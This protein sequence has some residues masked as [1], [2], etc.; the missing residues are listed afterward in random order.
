M[1]KQIIRFP[2]DNTN[3]GLFLDGILRIPE[4]PLGIVIFV[5]GSGSSKTSTRNQAISEKLYEN[6][7]GSFLFDLLSEEEQRSDIQLEKIITQIPGAVLNKFNIALLTRRLLTATE[8]IMNHQQKNKSML[9]YFAS[10]TGAAAALV[11]S[12]NFHIRSIIIRSGRTDLVT[13][14]IF[15]KIISPCLF[16]VGDG[17]KIII[18]IAKQTLKKLTNVREKNL[19]IIKNTSHMLEESGSIERVAFLSVTWIRNH[20]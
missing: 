5:H 3:S 8:W 16:V 17:E 7:I 2:A 14:D 18:K 1:G 9:S 11:A 6:N 13:N 4:N 20:S 15:P 12:T 10:S 19:S